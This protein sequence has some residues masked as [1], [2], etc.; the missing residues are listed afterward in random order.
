MYG[1]SVSSI[2]FCVDGS[3]VGFA[4]KSFSIALSAELRVAPGGSSADTLN[5]ATVAMSFC[6]TVYAFVCGIVLV[7]FQSHSLFL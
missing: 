6:D 7:Y 4:E 5:V 3:V 1:V 2:E